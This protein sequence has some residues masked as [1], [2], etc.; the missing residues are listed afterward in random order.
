[1][2]EGMIIQSLMGS[3]GTYNASYRGIKNGQVE[4]IIQVRRE[5]CILTKILAKENCRIERIAIGPSETLHK[6]SHS[7]NTS[8][9][10]KLSKSQIGY[11]KAG[12][13]SVW[14]ETPSCSSCS[15]FSSSFTEVLG[16]RTL[17]DDSVQYRLLLPSLKGLRALETRMKA[18]NLSYTILRVLPYVHQE[19][20]DRQREI[21]NIAM[22]SGYFESR[23]RI[24]LTELSEVIGITPSSL[25]EI[26]RRSLKKLVNFYFDHR[27]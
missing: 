17:C 20:T 11:K 2:D 23:S 13:H 8:F 27:P 10:E 4:A 14:V 21:L 22:E 24:S 25:S 18:A 6:I 3:Q 16:S 19:L 7:G 26:L 9:Q 1:M 12:K 5:D 15:F